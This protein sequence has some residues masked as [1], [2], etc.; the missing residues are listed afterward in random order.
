M[1]NGKQHIAIGVITTV[2]RF[3]LAV[4]FIFSGFVKAIDPLGTQYK[5]QDY[6]DAFG[7]TG[8]FPEFVLLSL[9]LCWGCWNFVWES[10]CSLVSD[11]SSLHVQWC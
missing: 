7:W 2:C 1:E 6:L 5:I 4:V 11:E 8:V 3:V 9:L 10:I